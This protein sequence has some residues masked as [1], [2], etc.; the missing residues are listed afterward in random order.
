M[1]TN[2][3]PI[4]RGQSAGLTPEIKVRVLVICVLPITIVALARCHPA[5]DWVKA[6]S[7]AQLMSLDFPDQKVGV[8]VL[9]IPAF[10]RCVSA[11]E[12]LPRRSACEGGLSTFHQRTAGRGQPPTINYG[13]PLRLH[14]T[15]RSAPGAPRCWIHRRSKAKTGSSVISAMAHTLKFRPWEIRPYP[16]YRSAAK[17][18][19]ERYLKLLWPRFC[20]K[21]FRSKAGAPK[22]KA[23]TARRS[24]H[25]GNART[26][27]RLRQ[28][29][30]NESADARMMRVTQLSWRDESGR[31]RA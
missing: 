22:T 6:A 28:N 31:V 15:K 4:K 3:S 20:E 25:C 5:P 23:K 30:R 1:L 16:H 2:R 24:H 29:V 18:S 17:P 27:E 7:V 9:W 13:F 14:F 26:L 12:R 11:G 19:I 8:Q 10:A 21:G